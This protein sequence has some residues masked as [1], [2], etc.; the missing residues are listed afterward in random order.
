MRLEREVNILNKSKISRVLLAASAGFVRSGPRVLVR[1]RGEAVEV[2]ELEF[3]SMGL[4]PAK[5]FTASFGV[6]LGRVLSSMFGTESVD[7]MGASHCAIRVRAGFVMGNSDEWWPLD[8]PDASL[9]ATLS[10]LAEAAATWF[11]SKRDLQ[12]WLGPPQ[13]GEIR[14]PLTEP[15]VLDMLGRRAEARA[16]ILERISEYGQADPHAQFLRQAAERAGISLE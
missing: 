10:E 16:A 4:P 3:H 11:E 2:V 13:I 12:S 7:R 14:M 5:H 9:T 15:V 1:P 6:F 8:M